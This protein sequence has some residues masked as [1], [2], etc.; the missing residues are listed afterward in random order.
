VAKEGRKDDDL[1]KIKAAITVEVLQI[2]PT[3]AV[4]GIFL[5]H[6]SVLI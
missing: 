2:L 5:F 1:K 3:T 4:L 6:Y